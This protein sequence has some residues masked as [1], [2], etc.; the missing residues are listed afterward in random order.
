MKVF[1]HQ[2]HARLT[3]G[4]FAQGD[5]AS[6]GKSLSYSLWTLPQERQRQCAHTDTNPAQA[7]GL[8]AVPTS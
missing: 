7:P 6:K 3:M 2:L 1:E 5:R 4:S 8:P